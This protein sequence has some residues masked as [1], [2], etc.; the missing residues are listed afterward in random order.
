MTKDKVE[1]LNCK[2]SMN[3]NIDSCLRQQFDASFH[4]TFGCYYPMFTAQNDTSKLCNIGDF[5]AAKQE[6]FHN[7]FTGS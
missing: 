7:L 3:R 4:E 5:D 2:E 6:E 1:H